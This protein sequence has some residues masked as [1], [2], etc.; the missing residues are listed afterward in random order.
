[1]TRMKARAYLKTV[2]RDGDEV[3][4]VVNSKFEARRTALQEINLS[5]DSREMLQDLTGDE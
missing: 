4:W 5:D 2:D 1:M 3:I